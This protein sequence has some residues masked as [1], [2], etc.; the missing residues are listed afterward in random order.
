MVLLMHEVEA[1]FISR[2]LA[3]RS[4][5]F[6]MCAT[7]WRIVGYALATMIHTATKWKIAAIIVAV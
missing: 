4:N 1:V 5:Y 2:T 6:K 3:I 7:H